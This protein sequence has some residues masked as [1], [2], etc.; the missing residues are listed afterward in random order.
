MSATTE[1]TTTA[2]VRGGDLRLADALVQFAHLI[3][4]LFADASRANGLTPQQAQLLCELMPRPMGMTEL[5]GLLNVERSTMTGLVD[6]VERRELVKRAPD[7][8]DR[9]AIQIALTPKGRRLA[10][11][12]YGAVTTKVDALTS[13]LAPSSA[14][15]LTK[16]V[17]DLL[18][19][20]GRPLS[21]GEEAS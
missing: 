7:P 2:A 17:V 4:H 11:K 9:R 12:S 19:D 6:R 16:I 3:D 13:G 20:N 10:M 18:A 5:T 1:P 14:T 21:T 15:R 8:K